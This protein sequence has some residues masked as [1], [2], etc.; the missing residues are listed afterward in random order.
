MNNRMLYITICTGYYS[1][2]VV[3]RRRPVRHRSRSGVPRTGHRARRHRVRRPGTRFGPHP[4]LG[5]RRGALRTRGRQLRLQ[6]RR[7]TRLHRPHTGGPPRARPGGHRLQGPT[8]HRPVARGPPGRARRLRGPGKDLLLRSLINDDGN[9]N[10]D[11]IRNIIARPARVR[12][13]CFFFF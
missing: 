1:Y 11:G 8:D 12:S 7:G 13:S 3:D 6:Y 4:E 9:D 2:A 5:Q 10:D